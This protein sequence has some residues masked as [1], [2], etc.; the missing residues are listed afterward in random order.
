MDVG[1]PPAVVQKKMPLTPKA[2]IYQRFGSE[3]CY[4]VEEVHESTQNEC[5]GLSIPQKGPCLYRCCLE[6]PDFSVISEAFKRKKD[7]E[8]S[9]AE[10]ALEKLGMS[11]TTDD[12]TVQDPWDEFVARFSY[13]FSN[14]FL[15]SH[16]P[17]SGHFRAAL[18]REGQLNG[19]I[20]ISVFA[21]CDT[22][23]SNLCKSINPKVESNPL[24]IISLI[25]RA[26]PRLS[27]SVSTSEE[28]LSMRREKPYPPEIIQ[29]VVNK[30]SSLQESIWVEVVRIPYLVEKTV[31]PLTLN[32]PSEGYYL[33][34]I[35][36]ELGL[37]DAFKVMISRTIG[38]ASSE[39]RL[40]FCASNS[41]LDPSLEAVCSKGFLNARASYLSGHLIDGDAIL[42]SI[43]YTW[44]PTDLFYDD[45][46]LGTY[47]R[48]LINMTPSGAYKLSREAILTAELPGT[49]TARTNWKGSFWNLICTF[50]RQHHLFEHVFSV[51]SNPLESPISPESHNLKVTDPGNE[52]MNA[53]GN[54]V[55]GSKQVSRATF[56]CGVK[57]FS[58][59]QD[60]II[61]CS[62]KESF[63]KQNAAIQNAAWKILSW[64]DKYF[65][66]P[67]IPL[68]DLMSFGDVLD[69]QFHHQQFYRKF[70]L[71][72]SVNKF[73]QSIGTQESRLIGS[74]YMNQLN[75]MVGDGGCPI[76]IE[77]PDSEV[78]PS[79]GA[80]VCIIYSICLVKETE[81][82]KELIESSEEFEFEI[83]TGSVMLC[84]E[85]VVTQMSEHQ[86]AKF[87]MNLPPQE[88]ILASARDT[89]IILP[90]LTSGGCNLECS[91]LLL[92]V[93][94]PM[95]DRMEQA[96][97]SPPLSKQRVEY[98]LQHIKE[99]CATSLVDF[100]CG[101]GSLLESLLDYPTSLEKIIGVDISQKGL[102]RAAK[103]AIA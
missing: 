38:K 35:A 36:R 9:A 42:A 24:L 88:W 79:N 18:R 45:V 70:S 43:G 33:D 44:K 12:S 57:I 21:I 58:K 2:I 101:S 91:I 67:D 14:E 6:L 71:C 8:Q 64:L 16:H 37:T 102:A 47:Y 15:L 40:Y 59:S 56:R 92:R 75:G 94:E 1:G 46:S 10:M 55:G 25:L 77:G 81:Y 54:A 78:S 29:S 87:Y 95:E 39:M 96:R 65:R 93:T 82:M 68:E 69:V 3:A 97:F 103:I 7:A 27:G 22:K 100:G 50:C 61:E 73:W 4:K 62:P 13:F 86:S 49:F 30:E 74:D 26:A 51:V 53:C 84:V 28:Q 85:G 48:V 66:K 99:Y 11:T 19:L 52:K 76:I 63:K 20:P 60:L 34:V 5:P 83:G 80:L 41:H 32:F 17:L 89:S 98:A 90:L 23:I 72:K 31:E